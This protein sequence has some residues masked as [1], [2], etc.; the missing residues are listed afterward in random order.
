MGLED[1]PLSSQAFGILQ[2]GLEQRKTQ[3]GVP[4]HQADMNWLNWLVV[5]PTHVKDISQIENLP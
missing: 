1:H 4:T 2:L 5:E 3:R